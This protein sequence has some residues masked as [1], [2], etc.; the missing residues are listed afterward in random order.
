M[1]DTWTKNM[2]FTGTVLPGVS[3]GQ[4]D[5]MKDF[6]ADEIRNLNLKNLPIMMHHKKGTS[7]GTVYH[8]W[9][10]ES[11]KTKII[12]S[13]E[14]KTVL[15]MFAQTA[16]KNGVFPDL[17]LTH[18]AETY[19]NPY[20]GETYTLKTPKEVSITNEGLRDSCHIDSFIQFEPEN[21]SNN[22]TKSDGLYNN[23]Q[24]NK[25]NFQTS[26]TN[27]HKVSSGS[28]FPL[29]QLEKKMQAPANS[30]T[31]Q[32]N[33]QPAPPQVNATPTPISANETRNTPPATNGSDD[34]I[35]TAVELEAALRKS[36][37]YNKALQEENEKMKKQLEELTNA[38]NSEANRKLEQTINEILAYLHAPEDDPYVQ[39][40]RQGAFKLNDAEKTA[41]RKIHTATIKASKEHMDEINRLQ[42]EVAELKKH[43]THAR[44][45]S[46]LFNDT[47]A[48][49]AN[50]PVILFH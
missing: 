37:D 9:V 41:F 45:S 17:S 16:I 44:I 50:P 29:Q 43:V 5:A 42:N 34:I 35:V 4:P 40:F 6:T 46:S 18:V 11:G 3:N 15:G 33:T 8:S 13:I 39:N 38:R 49:F 32:T 22:L 24:Q 25:S 36:A 7:M 23:S 27:I 14:D 10:D 12:G 20:T 2:V 21:K 19:L 31:G 30:Q 48:R 1:P 28:V 26:L 47:M